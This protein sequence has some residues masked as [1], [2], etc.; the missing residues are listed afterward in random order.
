MEIH[1]QIK[2]SFYFNQTRS[3]KYE[4]IVDPTAQFSN[5]LNNLKNAIFI[6]DSSF[7]I[8]NFR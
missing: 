4:T 6:I 8:I 5:F 2:E 1:H 3:R 7:K